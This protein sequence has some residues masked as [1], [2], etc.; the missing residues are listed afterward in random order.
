MSK[1]GAPRRR[2]WGEG[3]VDN[4]RYESQERGGD[5]KGGSRIDGRTQLPPLSLE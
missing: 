3:G 5:E 4:W 2:I 1:I